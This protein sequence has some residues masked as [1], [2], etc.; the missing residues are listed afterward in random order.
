MDEERKS[1]IDEVMEKR[2]GAGAGPS[3]WRLERNALK[4]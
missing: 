4:D 3:I 2:N 1:D